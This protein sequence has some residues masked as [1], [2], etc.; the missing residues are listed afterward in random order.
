[1]DVY[2]LKN[3]DACRKAVTWLKDAGVPHQ[4]HDIR[5]AGLGEATIARWVESAGWEKLLNRR[6]T[7]WRGLP[8]EA[9]D[10]VD[11]A[12]AVRLMT[13]HPAL[14]KRPVFVRGNDVLVGFD[15]AVRQCLKS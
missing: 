4:F 7:T 5:Q 14:V 2:G 3:C 11:E 9:K 6:G 15:D 13:L 8:D 1:M 10:G 12:D